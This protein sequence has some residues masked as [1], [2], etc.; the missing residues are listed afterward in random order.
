MI[1]RRS[2][3]SLV[4][5]GTA[6]LV[7][8]CNKGGDKASGGEA[9][10]SE[11][12]TLNGAGATFPYPLYSKWMSEYNKQHP[13]VRINYQSIGSGGGIRQISAR[14]VD[15]GAT[16][17]PMKDEEAKKAPGT[18]IHIPTTL[19]AVVV[20]Y[21]VPDYTGSLKLTPDVIADVFLGK[22]TKWNDERITGPNPD[23]K[24]PDKNISVVYRS[25]GSGTTAVFTEYLAKVSDEFKDKV[26][27]GK[28]VKWP[29]GLGAK[30]N[31][32]VTGQIKTTPGSIGYVELAYAL[33]NKLPTAAIK[34]KA[35]EF[36]QPAIAAITKAAD[37]VELPDSMHASITDSAT[38]GAYPISS[39][40]YILV[41]EDA[42]DAAKGKAVAEFLKWAIHDGQK[43]AD[44]LHYAPL[45]DAVVKKVET[46]LETLR[47]GD[48]KLLS[49]S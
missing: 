17:A 2:L 48:K 29:T 20:T 42:K 44:A 49:G 46:K 16:D 30:G 36:V 27:A 1:D 3:L 9:T 47:S 24:L 40:T 43:F 41:Y 22:I 31:E 15:F 18:L 37:G 38:P 19:G 8:A 39:F 28:S 4:L 7:V 35:G 5:A 26:G 12:V 6:A 14:T 25:D 11:N 32:G 34:N 33:Q 45:P 13:N 10:G 21:N 23:A